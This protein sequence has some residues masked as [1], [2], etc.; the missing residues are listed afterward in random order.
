MNVAISKETRVQISLGVIVV[1]ALGLATNW[2][3][4]LKTSLDAIRE[5]QSKHTDTLED[6]CVL[7]KT[8]VPETEANQ[9]IRSKVKCDLSR[10]TETDE[11]TVAHR[12]SD[13]D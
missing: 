8:S 7:V 2:L 1:V 11:A 13:R 3:A 4:D 5:T 6:L 10:R 9:I 12:R